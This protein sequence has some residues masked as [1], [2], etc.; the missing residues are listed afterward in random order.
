MHGHM[1][2]DAAVLLAVLVFRL[3]GEGHIVKVD[4]AL[5]VFEFLGV[6]RFALLR[7]RHDLVEAVI[8]CQAVLE[9]LDE[10]DQ[11]AHRGEEGVDIEQEHHQFAHVDLAEEIERA[12]RDQH[13]EIHHVGHEVGHRAKLPHDLHAAIARFN[14]DLVVMAELL[15]LML[16]AGIGAGDAD[17]GDRVFQVGVDLAHLHAGLGE[18]VVELMPHLGREPHDEGERGKDDERQRQRHGGHDDEH[19]HQRHQRDE[20]ILRAVV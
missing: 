1:G 3:I 5:D 7:L 6:G 15:L 17:A 12:A 11:L 4:R 18:G 14:V 16:A 9:L 20:Q 13:D 2:D 19:A 8:T 10:V